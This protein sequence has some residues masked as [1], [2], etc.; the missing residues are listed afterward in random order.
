MLWLED[1]VVSGAF[2]WGTVLSLSF[3]VDE[4]LPQ[5]QAILG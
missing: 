4:V 3:A 2:S 5:V 1:P